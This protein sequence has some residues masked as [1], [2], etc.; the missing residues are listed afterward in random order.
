ML[1]N[2]ND[3]ENFTGEL[4]NIL[5]MELSAGNKIC[6]TY[7]GDWPFPNSIMIFLD[8]P[9]ITPIRRDISGIEFRNVNDPHYWKAEY[10]DKILN[11]FLCCNFGNMPNFDPM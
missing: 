9:F 11:M 8:K 4:K 6:E 5:D 1:I 2:N 7:N 10:H 3:I